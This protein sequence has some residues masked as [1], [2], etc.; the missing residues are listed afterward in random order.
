MLQAL[1]KYRGGGSP[2]KESVVNW[3]TFEE[4]EGVPKA[5]TLNSNTLGLQAFGGGSGSENRVSGKVGFGSRL[6]FLSSHIGNAPINLATGSWTV[7]GCVISTAPFGVIA[8]TNNTG[9]ASQQW[10]VQIGAN[11]TLYAI[12]STDGVNN[13]AVLND[14]AH[15]LIDNV[16]HT[17]IFWRD[18]AANELGLQV[19]GNTP[20]TAS[21]S[22]A[23]S[24]FSPVTYPIILGGIGSQLWTSGGGHDETGTFNRA[25]TPTERTYLYNSGAWRTYSD[26]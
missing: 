19:D 9:D 23:T 4:N 11:G 14:G 21:F 15:S 1:T 18:T 6:S 26:L 16:W 8:Q 13:A 22:G 24:L 12:V 20:V 25:L 3:W 17:Y 5:N 10:R 7:V 2:L